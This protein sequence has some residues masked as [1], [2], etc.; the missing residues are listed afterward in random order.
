VVLH[1]PAPPAFLEAPLPV[2]SLARASRLLFV[3][4]LAAEKGAPVLLEA[5]RRAHAEEPELTLTVVG[6]AGQGALERLRALA[7]GLPVTFRGRLERADVMAAYRDHDIL[8]FPSIWS[9]PFAIVP[10]EAMA[11]GMAVVAS[12]AGGTPEAVQHEKTGLLV[13][14]GDVARL[15]ESLLRLTR[16]PALARAL[17]HAGA[18]RVRQQH[19]FA[20]FLDRLVDV[21]EQARAPRE[22][23]A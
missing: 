20:T 15:S 18:E 8:V 6:E 23:R 1:W 22:G 11:M 14:P 19:A 10:L 12:T 2:R 21:Y 4:S 13:P 5:F 9:E 3:G 7:E 16:D 17:G